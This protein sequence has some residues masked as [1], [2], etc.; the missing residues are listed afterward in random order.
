MRVLSDEILWRA[1]TSSESAEDELYVDH[2]VQYV[3]CV[4]SIF[5]GYVMLTLIVTPP[6]SESVFMNAEYAL[7]ILSN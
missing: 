6:K 3:T 5:N 2:V 4:K 7:H 1:S